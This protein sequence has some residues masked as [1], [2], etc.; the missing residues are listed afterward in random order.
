MNLAGTWHAIILPL[1]EN[2]TK[3]LRCLSREWTRIF[4]RKD[5]FT[6]GSARMYLLNL[7]HT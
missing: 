5:C 6:F 2:K 7:P 1:L 3:L 4:L